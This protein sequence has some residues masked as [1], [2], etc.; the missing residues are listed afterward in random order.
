MKIPSRLKVVLAVLVVGLSPVG[1]LRAGDLPFLK[2][3]SQL[4]P[5]TTEPLIDDVLRGVQSTCQERPRAPREPIRQLFEDMC[6]LPALLEQYR[7]QLS[8]L[9][10]DEYSGV[11][12]P[13]LTKPL[14][15]NKYHLLKSLAWG[16]ARATPA[17]PITYVTQ[18][19]V[20]Q[21]A[22]TKSFEA[23]LKLT[24]IWNGRRKDFPLYLYMYPKIAAYLGSNTL[25]GATLMYYENI[26]C[27]PSGTDRPIRATPCLHYKAQV[28]QEILPA[29][30]AM[31]PKIK[32]LRDGLEATEGTIDDKDLV[33]VHTIRTLHQQLKMARKDPEIRASHLFQAH[34]VKSDSTFY[35]GLYQFVRNA[36]VSKFTLAN[37]EL[38]NFYL[39]LSSLLELI[40]V[41][42]VLSSMRDILVE[43]EQV[44]RPHPWSQRIEVEFEEV[45]SLVLYFL[46][47]Q[48]EEL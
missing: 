45:F 37:G 32:Q 5:E 46:E 33:R 10:K 13:E 24:D 47:A 25:F 22:I 12:L 7:N 23:T 15:F 48:N 4:S 26:R 31:A 44:Q 8:L 18:V 27:E 40:H 34:R 3:I 36:T 14:S 21:L 42:E 1:P 30:T 38:V 41:D 6:L 19:L 17:D 2:A 20:L 29:L 39:G 11:M 16:K 35:Q 43:G 28:A 9:E